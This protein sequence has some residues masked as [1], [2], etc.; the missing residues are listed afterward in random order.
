MRIFLRFKVDQI[1]LWVSVHWVTVTY[2]SIKLI[3]KSQSLDLCN[4]PWPHLLDCAHPFQL[5][6][7]IFPSHCSHVTSLR[8]LGQEINQSLKRHY[9]VHYFAPSQAVSGLPKPKLHGIKMNPPRGQRQGKRGKIRRKTRKTE[10][11][12]KPKEQV[13]MFWGYT[14]YI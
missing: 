4:L 12:G 14:M 2:T 6:M 7:R 10:E 8:S 3:L 1:W 13:I 9:E 11:E 5:K